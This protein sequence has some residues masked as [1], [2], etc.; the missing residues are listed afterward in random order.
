LASDDYVDFWALKWAD[1]LRVSRRTVQAKGTLGLHGWL[2]LIKAR[3]A[4]GLAIDPRAP[5]AA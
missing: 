1:L 5:T 3:Q 2:R 4:A